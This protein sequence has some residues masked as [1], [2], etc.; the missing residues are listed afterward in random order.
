ML[1]G[2]ICDG[3]DKDV[4]WGSP[5]SSLST[6]ENSILKRIFGE[7]E[8]KKR[9]DIETVIRFQVLWIYM[10]KNC[11]SKCFIYSQFMMTDSLEE[12]EK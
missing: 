6:R 3:G 9:S 7:F 12:V 8:K 2:Q 1:G 10:L 4:T 5:K 11:K